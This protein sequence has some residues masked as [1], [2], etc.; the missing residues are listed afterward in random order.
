MLMLKK[1]DEI[2]KAFQFRIEQLVGEV[3]DLPEPCS[4]LDA[5]W[6]LRLSKVATDKK[7]PKL[8]RKIEKGLSKAVRNGHTCLWLRLFWFRELTFLEK[9]SL[10]NEFKGRGFHVE[11]P[12]HDGYSY[13][14]D[15]SISLI[16]R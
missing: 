3:L 7:M 5:N 8:I 16:W 9:Q 14:G 1:E 4:V 13:T 11:F 15:S 2:E 12:G 10:L 6:A